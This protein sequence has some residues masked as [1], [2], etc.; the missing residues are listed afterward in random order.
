MLTVGGV[1]KPA[2]WWWEIQLARNKYFK[3]P[4]FSPKDSYDLAS[5]I[6]TG[7]EE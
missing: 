6:K 3:V 7:L 5:L 1:S 4:P 2:S